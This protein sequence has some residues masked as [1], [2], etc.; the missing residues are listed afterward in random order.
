[1]TTLLE[2]IRVQAGSGWASDSK[3]AIGN[4]TPFNVEQPE[5]KRPIASLAGLQSGSPRCSRSP[6]WRKRNSCPRQKA[7]CTTSTAPFPASQSVGRRW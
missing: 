4:Y 3:R 6:R 1:M 7:F 2:D 5:P